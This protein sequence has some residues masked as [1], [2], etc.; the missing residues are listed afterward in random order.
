[1]DI[2][3]SRLVTELTHSC[4]Q[5]INNSIIFTPTS[6][7]ASSPLSDSFLSLE[8][9]NLD[10]ILET[11]STSLHS[12]LL[13][14]LLVDSSD[15]ASLLSDV[16]G[17]LAALHGEVFKGGNF[18]AAR[19]GLFD[20]NTNTNAHAHGGGGG[21]ADG[22]ARRL[23]ECVPTFDHS[24][25]DSSKQNLNFPDFKLRLTAI[26]N[27]TYPIALSFERKMYV[28]GFLPTDPDNCD[29]S[30]GQLSKL[31]NEIDDMKVSEP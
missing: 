5:H 26:K 24:S 31:A 16:E 17:V 19:I 6:I 23:L 12:K 11:L 30:G 28:M 27:S 14:K 20:T 1:M 22:L 25:K 7:T 18:L 2:H 3:Y 10:Q 8:S 4:G 21:L 13:E 15:F 9:F 29:G